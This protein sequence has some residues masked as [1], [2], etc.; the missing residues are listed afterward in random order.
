MMDRSSP[1]AK[2]AVALTTEPSYLRAFSQGFDITFLE[3]PGALSEL[4]QAERD[5]IARIAIGGDIKDVLRDTIFIIEKPSEGAMLASILFISTDG[6]HLIE[7][8]APSLPQEY[9]AAIDGIAIGPVVGSCGTAAFRGEPVFVTDIANDPLWADF[10]DLALKHGLRACWSIPIRAADG[11]VLGTFANYYREPR[12]PTKHEMEVISMFAQAS[13][14]AIERH[15]RDLE[16]Q[17]EEEHRGLLIRELNHRVKN[18]FAIASALVAMSG[19]SA[20]SVDE[21]TRSI[22]GRLGAL[23]RAHELVQP[24]LAAD[25]EPSQLSLEK[26][27]QH[28]LAPYETDGDGRHLAMDG[29][30]VMITP[31][32]VSNLAL[33]FHELATNAAKYGALTTPTG[34]VRVSWQKHP[35]ELRLE[36]REEGGPPAHLPTKTGFGS[37]L[38]RRSIEGQLR[39]SI[40]YDWRPEGLAVNMRIPLTSLCAL[41]AP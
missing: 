16:R 11:R 26:V 4:L 21:L 39:G 12:T 18:V 8:A 9:N 23:G 24:G 29:P 31:D 14:I 7:G 19:R 6:K 36:W 37:T 10:R 28:I 5:I 20:T 34:V 40:A 30:S 2:H 35:D 1:Q 33:V 13:A 41:I 15:K 32:A 25:D 3:A 22:Q 38:S 17:R 27:L